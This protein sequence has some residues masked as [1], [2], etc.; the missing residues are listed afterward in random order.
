LNHSVLRIISSMVF[1]VII[2]TL[3]QTQPI[4][5]LPAG[6]QEFYLPLPTGSDLASPYNGTYSIFKA[7]EPPI[8][9]ASGMHYVVGV[10]ASA[11]NTKIYY[12]HWENGLSTGTTS[13][14]V[15][16]LNKGQVHVFESSAIPVPRGT[17]TKYD[18]GD[19]VFVSGSLLQLVVSTWTEDQGTLFADAWEVYPIQAW[20]KV[21]PVPVGENLANSPLLY[22]AFT[23]VYA[24]VMSSSNGNNITIVDPVGPVTTNV[25]LNRGQTYVY[26]VKGAGTTITGSANVEVQ[27]MT[28]RR[29]TTGYEMRGYTITPNAYWRAGYYAPVP[30][31]TGSNCNLYLYNPN[32]SQI[33]VNYEDLSGTGS[34]TINANATR[35]YRD[36]AGRYVPIGSGAYVYTS[37]ALFWG[38]G[39]GDDGSGIWDW[40]YDLIPTNFLGTDNYVS[41]AP[42][43]R[44]LASNTVNGSPVYVVA[45]NNNTTVFVDYGPNNGVFDATYNLNRLHAIQ[46]YDPDKDN[47]GMHIVS[48]GP[49]AVCWGESPDTAGQLD[50]YLDMGYTTLPLPIEWIDVALQVDKTASP[51]QILA[52][53]ET[54]FTVN[55][56]VP[57]TAAAV[58]SVNLVDT[59]PAGWQYVA[60]SG[61]PSD[62]T[63]ITGT[64]AGGYI[65]T[66]NTNWN[67]NTG[68]SQTI[69]FR[70]K[71]TASADQS[72][73]NRNVAAATGQSLGATLTAD[74]DAFVDVITPTIVLVKNGI[75]D[76][77]VID[78]SGQANPGDKI[79]YTFTVTN[80]GNV[81]LTNVTVT[82]PLVT[83]TGSSI[84]SLAPGDSNSSNFSGSY[85]L[86]QADINAGKVDN[87]AMVTGTPPTGP[88]VTNQSANTVNVSQSAGIDL[89]KNGILDMT[90]TGLPG[91]ADAGDKINY[92]FIVTNTGNVTLTN[93]TVTDPL[94]TVTGGSIALLEPGDYNN[95]TFS[96]SY[97]LTQA[98]INAGYVDNTA[99]VTGT[100]PG[101][102]PVTDH[103]SE[104]VNIPQSANIDLL[105]NGLL[106]MTVTGLP[107][108]AD[109]GDKINYSFTVTNTGNV[110]LTNV[111]VTDPLVTVTGSP[112]AYLLPGASNNSTFTGSYT[113]TQADIDA[114]H[115][116]NTATVT[117]TTPGN[118]PVS[119]QDSKTV[120]LP[121]SAN[122][123][124]VKN[125]LLDM[126]VTGLPGQAD[127]GD[128]INYSF[129]VT[130]TGNVTLTNV[131]VTDPMFTVSGGPILLAPGDSDTLTFSGSYTLTQADI[132]A[133][134]VNNTATVTGTTPGNTPV[135]DQ[136]SKTVNIPQSANID[137]LKNG[138]LDMTVTGLPGQADAGDK[139]NYSF[140]VTNTGNV[141]LTN[142]I[143]TDPMF[144]VSGGPILLAP[145]DSDTLT[146]SGSYTLTQADINA[147]YV[148]NTATVTGTTPGNTPVT[149]QDSETVNIPQSANLDLVKNGLL[150]MTVTG[151]PGQADAGDQ[152]NYSFTVTNTGNVTLTS[153]TVTDPM[154]TVSGGPISLAPGD[155]DILT[156]SGSYTLTQADINA[157]YVDNTATVT[158]TTPGLTNVTDHD[159]ETVNIPQSA[160]IDLVK[161]GLLDMTIAGSTAQ[162][163]AGDVINYSFTVTNTGNVTLTNVTVTD[164][165]F[166]VSGGSISLAPG[167]SDTLTFS[168]SYTLTQPDI[169]AGYVDN[170][171]TVTGTTPGLTTVTDQDSK[172]VQIVQGPQIDL[173][174]NGILDMNIMGP[175]DQANVGD[176]IKYTFTVTNTGNVNLTNVTVIDPMFTVSGGTISLAVGE[177]DSDTFTGSYVLT[178][179]DI[180][181]GKVD[182]TATATGTTP[183]EDTVTDTHSTTVDIPQ[184]KSIALVKNGILDMTV[185]AP[186]GQANVGDEINYTFT[187]T[188]TGNVPL[189]NVTVAD[190]R[191]TVSGGSISLA[192]GESDSATFS[193]S[194]VLTQ[195]DINT[196]QVDNTATAT[197]TTPGNTP[198]TDEHSTTV[199]VP[200]DKSIA[201]VKD[202]ILDMTVIAPSGQAN[203]GDEINYTF[204]VTNTGNVPLTN[205]TVADPRF[206]VSGGP[207]S[208]AVGESDS[209]TFTG[210][211]V[212][213]QID[214]NAGQVDNTATATGTTPGNT[215]V[216]DEHSTTVGIPQDEG[217]SLIKGGILDMNIMGPADQAN[218]GDQINY[219][220]T[221]TNTGNVPLT[222]VTVTDP[223]FTVSG[224]SISLA[225]G[226][227]DIATFSG[228]YTLTQI[229]IN[230]GKVDNTATATGTTPGNTPVT[231][232]HSTTVDIPQD[233]SIELVKVGV[234]DM[235]ATAPSGQANVGD[236]IN[237][238]FTVTNTGNVPLTNVTVTDP[239]FTVSGGSISLAVGESDI[240][241]FSGS[242]VLT[243]NDINAGKVDNTATATGT[244]PGNNP[245]TDEHST[246]VDIPQDES[247][248]LVKDGVLD[249]TVVDPINEANVGDI[250]NYFFALENTGNVPLTDVT[251][252]DPKITVSGGP[253][254]LAIG[255]FNTS[256]FTGSYTLTQADI[257]AGKVDNTATATGTTPGNTQV[258]DEHSKTVSIPESPIGGPGAGIELVKVG[259]LD[260]TVVPPDYEVNAGDVIR[261]T[262][263][264]TNTGDVVLT[265]VV[266]TD[267]KIT[268][269]GGHLDTLPVGASDST[270]FTGTYTLTKADI[271]ANRVDNTAVVSAKPPSG[272]DIDDQNTV[273]VTIPTRQT[274]LGGEVRAIDLS[275]ILI[276]W[277]GLFALVL[278][279][280]VTL[281]F[282][283]RRGA[284]GKKLN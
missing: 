70:G 218:V 188:N 43:N 276:P 189:T 275:G 104:T 199:D 101:N 136:D 95:S 105:K 82:D 219:T 160:N 268:V 138:I 52:G 274:G 31:W 63:T 170:T 83:V 201:L 254:S 42:G 46:I 181:A 175:A 41:W 215:P 146:F 102:T 230:A 281:F 71:A 141:T 123:D 55:V 194:Y 28:G 177:S 27:V 124:L 128:V 137:L 240:A 33:T 203:V 207:I 72:N 224:G 184:D 61:A 112:I 198:V 273:R 262:F 132:N 2:L 126:T 21:Y 267:P 200:Q 78:P 191:F 93:V 5:A 205:V 213:T 246:T 235:T 163:D 38:I 197:G 3:F 14:E 241:T 282:L 226:E 150:D 225:V 192:V 17:A 256:T 250:I 193:G 144:T 4:A 77:T 153:V 32:A 89:H 168:G 134:Y 73:P 62:P 148:D 147:G 269:I 253:I 176:I 261:Y 169:N 103:D 178:Q 107:G 209:D 222:N 58:T 145:G 223:M 133:G 156:F 86:T 152:I 195:N 214:I 36:G 1:L 135:S 151:L 211:Y 99:T 167:D 166:T 186:S 236:I 92:A 88:N 66:W 130:N 239:M 208:L 13:D 154:F 122:I 25:T 87:T 182:N 173:V 271:N 202:G 277:S 118:T 190:P 16:S 183:S 270:T 24:L 247:I 238:T 283:K 8:A 59:L 113:L 217:I 127:A 233:E 119:D 244:S 6:F 34:F 260:M 227:S 100:T 172:T 96:G 110:T 75:L 212:L 248:E 284:W 65:L 161:N 120:N 53:Q 68:S 187:V 171:A 255:A 258:T 237:Y 165:M 74:D 11:D 30:S 272:P 245:V 252:T 39:A 139:I 91:Q 264:V 7:I 114:G 231:D 56:S 22:R 67:I 196:G 64:L 106:D 249:M 35:S 279:S 164:P 179:I 228:S 280:C 206:S 111:I 204:T 15:V 159:S 108:Q 143:V 263:T 278:A 9:S 158:G 121:Q 48:N 232:E 109:A 229:D 129:T 29:D 131:T 44:T 80:A 117:G 84:A 40:G 18:G 90:V 220:F 157:G 85:T 97:T 51:T 60:G 142:V 185:I 57:L 216:T 257:D 50:P 45:L 54:L 79:N 265:D 242:Y 81:T 116:D 37:G 94:V 19:R 47:T 125:G 115:V 49:V 266:V 259:V 149:D 140:T 69:T 234:L 12:D 243:Q 20:E 98:D 210:S 155:S 174:K 23:Y 221:V 180:N 10:T 76:M 26:E 162:A 251:I